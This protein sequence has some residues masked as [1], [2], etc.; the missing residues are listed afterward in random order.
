MPAYSDSNEKPSRSRQ[1]DLELIRDAIDEFGVI[2]RRETPNR[3]NGLDDLRFKVGEQWLAADVAQRNA[4]G[5]P[6]LTINQLPQFSNEVV[7]EIRQNPPQIKIQPGEGGDPDTAKTIDGLVREIQYKSAASAVYVSATT[8]AVDNGFGY[9]RVLTEYCDP[10]SFDQ[11]IRIQR[12]RNPFTVYYGDHINFDGSDV[13][14]VFVTSWVREDDF[15]RDYPDAELVS[16]ESM[17]DGDRNTFAEWA[18][19][20]EL[21][22]AEY[23]CRKFVK[24]TLVMLKRVTPAMGEPDAM[25]IYDDEPIPPNYVQALREVNGKAEAIKREAVIEEVWC[26]K[27]TAHAVLS[28]VK[29]DG[30]Y[31][32]IIP[33]WGNETDIEGNVYRSGLIRHAKD[34]MRSYNYW[35]TVATE[36]IAMAPRA[37]FIGPSGFMKGNETRWA[38][39]NRV[40]F[41]ALEYDKD[42][43]V[44][45]GGQVLPPP[46]RQPFP[47]M[48]QGV[49]QMMLICREN[50]RTTIG[51]YMRA[52]LAP[53]G[54]EQSGSALR[55]ERQKGE[56]SSFQ[57]IDNLARAIEFAG[58]V[59]VDLI[60]H[61]Y[62]RAG[63][64]VLTRGEDGKTEYVE[65]NQ[66]DGKRNL[67]EGDYNVVVNVGPGYT[68]RRQE[69][70]AAMMELLKTD[71]TISPY[72][73][74]IVAGSLDIDDAERMRDRLRAAL[75]P[76]VKALEEQNDE[77]LMELPPKARE[78]VMSARSQVTQMKQYADK[79]G[80]ALQEAAKQLDDKQAILANDRYKVDS[81]S[82]SKLDAGALDAAV[83]LAT[84][85]I[86]QQN[87]ALMG[88]VSG[89]AAALTQVTG[90][91]QNMQQRSQ[92]LAKAEADAAA[93]ASAGPVPATVDPNAAAG[94][95][96][97]AKG[98]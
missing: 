13:R 52:E 69:G 23:F 53:D 10:K 94:V 47:E 36:F 45:K 78:A 39:A 67:K 27:L 71:P 21:R 38:N 37:P 33:V 62:D 32:P 86:A 66:P 73:R 92:E 34:S 5:R 72:V 46:Q 43:L 20:N 89:M 70:A 44:T 91:I 6:L 90:F 15:K 77:A 30:K 24:K 17:N 59:I 93:K 11:E 97:P 16:W 50:L 55:Q 58:K 79:L 19:H 95:A 1:A 84:N 28:R 29:L 63:R 56:L 64:K 65:V 54:P 96:Q 25:T 83:K 74:D 12:I 48:P 75:P 87:K 4:D 22:I 31:I 60:P 18:R 41:P 14:R 51:K 2:A 88:E 61:V 40:S 68:T 49:M 9:F 35:F 3:E 82:Q 7:N 98:M 8:N 26:Y 80:Q 81:A 57:Y 85:E 42:S 76:E